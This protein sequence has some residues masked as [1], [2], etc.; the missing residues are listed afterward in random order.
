MKAK[1]MR[2]GVHDPRA[3][4]LGGLYKPPTG[5]RAPTSMLWV[6]PEETEDK[7]FPLS[8]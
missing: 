3:T 8:R 2:K 5:C 6:S 7:A 1:A 4:L